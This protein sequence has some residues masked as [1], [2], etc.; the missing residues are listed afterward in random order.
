[1]LS[2]RTTVPNTCATKASENIKSRPSY[3]L[4]GIR[5]IEQTSLDISKQCIGRGVFAKCF[6]GKLAHIEVCVKVFRRGYEYTFPAEAHILLQC[7]HNN[8]PWIYGAVVEKNKRAIIM[9]FHGS[10]G[11]S[12]SLHHALSTSALSPEQ[13][14]AV[15]VGL[16]SAVKYLHEKDILH[17]DIKS[18]N[19]I[20][21]YTS[22]NAKG[23][24]VDLGKACYISDCRKYDLTKEE[25][26]K[27]SINHPQIAPDLRDGHCFQS[28]ASDIYSA[29]RVLSEIN[30]L[31][32]KVPALDSL[33]SMCK[34]YSSC[35]RPNTNDVFSSINFL[36]L[37]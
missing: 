25:K 26:K 20:V 16:I 9:S 23:V 30:R 36:F 19:V 22:S 33:S 4:D 5:Q 10:D 7:N 15:I 31:V 21:E 32:L 12:T 3:S 14:K 18:D 11:V 13:G 24:L 1:M 34:E 29:G 6:I 2:R 27:Y 37:P 17:N 28:F 35:S 8:L